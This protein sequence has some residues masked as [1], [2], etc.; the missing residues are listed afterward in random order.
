MKR[1]AYG[2]CTGLC[3]VKGGDESRALLKAETAP[4]GAHRCP[5]LPGGRFWGL[6]DRSRCGVLFLGARWK[7]MTIESC[8]SAGDVRCRLSMGT[9]CPESLS[10]FHPPFSSEVESTRPTGYRALTACFGWSSSVQ[11]LP[12]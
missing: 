10:Y 1:P 6:G 5:Q 2:S 11:Y 12:S 4:G 3:G 8:S 9:G 7:E